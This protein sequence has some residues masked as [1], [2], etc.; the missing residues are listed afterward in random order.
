TEEVE[1]LLER[2]RELGASDEALSDDVVATWLRAEA[3]LLEASRD[4]SVR[5]EG[6]GDDARLILNVSI[7]HAAAALAGAGRRAAPLARHHA[8]QPKA[9]VDRPKGIPRISRPERERE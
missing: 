3:G 7:E 2:A 6:E 4:A 8:E 1:S 5:L 9:V